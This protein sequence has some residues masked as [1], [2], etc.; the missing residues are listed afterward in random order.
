MLKTATIFGLLLSIVAGVCHVPH[1]SIHEVLLAGAIQPF[2][3]DPIYEGSAETYMDT[4]MK[5]FDIQ[6]T[7]KRKQEILKRNATDAFS[8]SVRLKKLYE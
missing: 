5:E 6:V 4:M 1:H 7:D 3:I 8:R 2:A